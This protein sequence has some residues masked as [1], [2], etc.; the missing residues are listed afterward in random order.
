M[1][2][3]TVSKRGST[4]VTSCIYKFLGTLYVEHVFLYSDFSCGQNQ[5]KTTMGMLSISVANHPTLKMVDHKFLE[6]GH[7]HME[8]DTD[9]SVIERAKKRTNKEIHWPEDW[10]QFVRVAKS[11]KP[12][13]VVVLNQS[14]I[15]SYNKL[16][17][18]TL[19]VPK[20]CQE[21]A[22]F[23][24]SDVKWFRY[25]K[26]EQ[27]IVRY[28]NTLSEEDPFFTLD[29]REK[30]DAN[31]DDY[32]FQSNHN[33]L[34]ITKEKKKDLVSLL[35]LLREE[36]RPFYEKL[37]QIYKATEVNIDPDLELLDSQRDLDES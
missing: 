25:T 9:H 30:T 5:N 13:Q 2:N 33:T 17:K 8:C 26:E 20:R 28:K 24:I 1:W 35:P 16:Y 15:Y 11:S 32:L 27:G 6:P 22:P 12:F 7:T 37:P 19:I 14:S 10:C 4:E 23:K 34:P 3:E 31:L 18:G 21:N 29:L 36:V